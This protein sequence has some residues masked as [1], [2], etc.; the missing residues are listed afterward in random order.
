MAC[1]LVVGPAPCHRPPL[2]LGSGIMEPKARGGVPA[3]SNTPS[4]TQAPAGPVQD[5]GMAQDDTAVGAAGAAAERGEMAGGGS[6]SGGGGGSGGSAAGTTS[7]HP[8]P[9]PHQHQH[10]QGS[11]HGGRTFSPA[12]R[13]NLDPLFESTP[14]A[15]GTG[16]AHPPRP[17]PSA[18]RAGAA[19]KAPPALSPLN[20]S[21]EAAANARAHQAPGAAGSVPAPVSQPLHTAHGPGA[22]A[23]AYLGGMA[24]GT[25]VI[26]VHDSMAS[27]PHSQAHPFPS[28]PGTAQGPRTNAQLHFQT[29][30]P[31]AYGHGRSH[32]STSAAVPSVRLLAP[33]AR[34]RFADCGVG[35]LRTAASFPAPGTSATR[36][37]YLLQR[38]DRLGTDVPLFACLLLLLLR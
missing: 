15:A 34:T 29:P 17:H 19:G 8:H 6:G 23:G 1:W 24:S 9:H 2:N 5:L 14:S 26:S 16:A 32:L 28:R 37:P 27:Y 10:T 7:P 35:Q 21:P 30:L 20:Q 13:S 18:I 38:H 4:N 11:E 22:A 3:P 36:T 33:F 31:D 12:P 25:P